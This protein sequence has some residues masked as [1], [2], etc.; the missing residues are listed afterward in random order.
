MNAT[1]ADYNELIKLQRAVGLVV[2]DERLPDPPPTLD[3]VQN[4]IAK[5]QA[6]HFPDKVVRQAGQW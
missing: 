3:E 5:L 2:T 4:E 6:I 1:Q